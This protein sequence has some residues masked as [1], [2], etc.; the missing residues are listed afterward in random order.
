MSENTTQVVI[1][2]MGLATALGIDVASTWLAVSRGE[3]GVKPMPALEQTPDPDKGGGQAV[4]LPEDFQPDQPRHTR[5]LAWTIRQA[6]TSAGA[7]DQLPYEAH[8]CGVVLGT[9]LHGMRCAGR[10]VRTDDPG[11]LDQLMAG[12]IAAACSK[13]AGFAGFATTTC[14]ACSSGLSAVALGVSLLRQGKLDF[15]LAI[16]YD[17]VSEYVYAGFNSMRLVATKPLKPFARD[18]EGMKVGEGYGIVALERA[19]DAVRRGATTIAT[20]QGFSATSDVHH[21]TQPHPEGLGASRA[22]QTALKTSK[23]NP[24]DINMVAAHATATPNNDAAEFAALSNTFGS[25]LAGMPV[26]GFKAHLGHTLGGAGIVELILSATAMQHQSVPPTPNVMPEEIEFDGLK[27]VTGTEP[28]RQSIGATM[29]LSL[30]FGGSNTCMILRKPDTPVSPTT[31]TTARP[32]LI[33]GM[34]LVLPG[35]IGADAFVDHVASGSTPVTNIDDADLS[36]LI[37]AKRTRRMSQYGKLTLAATTLAY[38]DASIED[39]EA[40]GKTAYGLLGTAHG[41]QNYLDTYYRQ[42]VTEGI[43]AANPMLFAEGVPNV[44]SAHLSVAFSIQGGCQTLIGTRHSGLEAL[45]LAAT[46]IANGTWDRVVVSVAEETS[47]LVERVYRHFGQIGP[48]QPLGAGA[49]T[50]ILESESS[51]NARGARPLGRLM[52]Y[53]MV[54]GRASEQEDAFRRCVGEADCAIGTGV[55]ERMTRLEQAALHSVTDKQT[56]TLAQL[57]G[58]LHETFSVNPLACMAYI[59]KTGNTFNGTD[60]IKKAVCLSG[61]CSGSVAALRFARTV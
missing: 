45:S 59:L 48:D 11:E 6:L 23:L 60:S 39:I 52:D 4:D 34:G 1:T 12:G 49:A 38:R 30:G 33:T 28:S 20:V 19:E 16:G 50:F 42:V 14:S 5:Y 24:V 61:D 29:N 2:G 9:T 27:L 26:V 41:A 21:L 43:N 36:D 32:V 10:F 56:S 18:R 57:R 7:A 25:T 8:R 46:H 17:A 13:A 15:V 54:F 51:A 35:I 37:N 58:A 53:A 31:A 44:G 55:S 22:I 3:C 47:E 40:F